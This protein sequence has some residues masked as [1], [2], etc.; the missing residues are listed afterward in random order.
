M[1]APPRGSGAVCRGSVNPIPL[2]RLAEFGGQRGVAV[3]DAD[4]GEAGVEDRQ[5]QVIE[6]EGRQPPKLDRSEGGFE[7]GPGDGPVGVDGLRSAPASL[8]V[9]DPAIQQLLDRL[10]APGA[11]A[12]WRT[13]H[14]LGRRLGCL[15]LGSL[16]G[17]ADLPVLAG[18][19]S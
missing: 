6:L 17:S 12:F 8:Q 10:V 7:T 1:V 4:G 16:E 15:A 19:Q 14:Q 13:G 11:P 9:V 3:A 18:H 5:V 2:D